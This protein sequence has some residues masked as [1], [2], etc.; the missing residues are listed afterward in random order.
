MSNLEK[1]KKF[2]D[3]PEGKAYMKRWFQKRIVAE[4]RKETMHHYIDSLSEKEF[5]EKLNKLIEKHDDAYIDKCYAK[6]RMPHPN[7]LLSAVINTAVAFGEEVDPFD[8]FSKTFMSETYKYQNYFFGYV[9]GQGTV[10]LIWNGNKE[11]ILQ[12]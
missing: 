1:I 5:E 11:R 10:A 8:E 6:G 12:L 2:F 9:H 7:N 4:K 3:S